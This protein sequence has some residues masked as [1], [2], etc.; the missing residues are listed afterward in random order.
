MNQLIKKIKETKDTSLALKYAF[1]KLS[2]GIKDRKSHFRLLNLA[3][4][5]PSDLLDVANF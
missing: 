2:E 5:K 3:T 1:T 4:V